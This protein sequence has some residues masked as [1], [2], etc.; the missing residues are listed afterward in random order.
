MLL[1]YINTWIIF[2]VMICLNAQFF[3]KNEAAACESRSFVHKKEGAQFDTPSICLGCRLL[4]I[5]FAVAW[6]CSVF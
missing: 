1:I 3:E 5:I 2:L 6:V 4:W